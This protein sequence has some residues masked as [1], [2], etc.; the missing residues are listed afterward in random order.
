[1]I[2]LDASILV[3]YFAKDDPI[4]TPKAK[5]LIDSLSD[6]RPGYVPVAAL[7][8]LTWVMDARHKSERTEI[9]K[10]VQHLLDSDELNVESSAMV[11]SAL[12]LFV[13]S[14]VGFA[15]C[16]I[17]RACQDVGCRHT[18]T[19]DRKASRAIGMSLVA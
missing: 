7:V 3:R 11:A 12:H 6:D 8:E 19:F 1:M 2:G 9:Q 13:T 15:D 10:V 5:A 14:N 17:L 16:L 4:Q 18:A